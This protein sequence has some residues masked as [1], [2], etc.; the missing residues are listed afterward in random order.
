MN[1]APVFLLW[2][3]SLLALVASCH[4]FN[5]SGKMFN[6]PVEDKANKII[7]CNPFA[8]V[9]IHDCLEQIPH[10]ANAFQKEI[11]DRTGKATSLSECQLQ[12][13]LPGFWMEEN[14]CQKI[15]CNPGESSLVDC[16]NT[17]PFA[18]AAHFQRTCN[19]QG[20]NYLDE[21]CQLQQCRPEYQHQGNHCQ[22]ASCPAGEF[23]VEGQCLEV[24]PGY[25]SPA[26][27][28][29]RY[30]CPT[31]TYSAITNAASCLNCNNRP[32]HA[33]EVTYAATNQPTI[34]NNCPISS[35]SCTDEFAPDLATYSCKVLN[36]GAG[37]YA[38]AGKCQNVGAGFYSGPSDNAR[39]PCP[40]GF[41]SSGENATRC[42]ACTLQIAYA[43]SFTFDFSSALTSNS[44]PLAS[45]SCLNGFHPN[46]VAKSCDPLLCGA[47]QYLANNQCIDVTAGYYSPDKDNNRY[48]CP[49][50]KYSPISKASACTNCTNQPE[51]AHTVTYG[52][53]S[54]LTSNTCP[55]SSFTCQEGYQA[56]LANK[57]CTP[58][59][60]GTGQY[61]TNGQCSNVGQG[62]YSPALDNQRYLCPS[63][64]YSAVTNAGQ[65][66]PCTNQPAN[67]A[68]VTYGESSGLMSNM[69]PISSLT[70][71]NGY[72]VNNSSKK[73]E[74][75]PGCEGGKYLVNGVCINVGPGYFS[76]ANNNFRQPCGTNYYSSSENAT[77]CTLCSNLPPNSLTA[78]YAPSSAL[79]SNTC[80]IAGL[81]C[82][83]G[84]QFNNTNKSCD[85]LQNCD[86]GMCLKNGLCTN[87]GPGAFSPANNNICYQCLGGTYSDLPNAGFCLPC[88]NKPEN[89]ATVTYT[90][91]LGTTSNNCPIATFS[92]LLGYLPNNNA[93]TCTPDPAGIP[94]KIINGYNVVEL[95]K[96]TYDIAF[97]LL[98]SWQITTGANTL[99]ALVDLGSHLGHSSLAGNIRPQL[100]YDVVNK[101]ANANEQ[102]FNYRKGI[103]THVNGIISALPSS[104]TTYQGICPQCNLAIIKSV[105][106]NESIAESGFPY[107]VGLGAGIVQLSWGVY[108]FSSS[109]NS[110]K[111]FCGMPDP[112]TWITDYCQTLKAASLR[113]TLIIVPSGNYD[114]ALA[115][116]YRGVQFPANSS[117]AVAVGGVYKNFTFAKG[118]PKSLSNS[119]LGPEQEFVAPFLHVYSTMWPGADWLGPEYYQNYHPC[120]DSPVP[121]SGWGICSGT[122]M[123]AAFISGIAGLIKSLRPTI[124]NTSLRELLR[125]SASQN[126]NDVTDTSPCRHQE[127][128][129]GRPQV[130]KIITAL[131]GAKLLLDTPMFAL[132]SAEAPNLKLF[133]TSPQLAMSKI[134]LEGYTP[135][136]HF[137]PGE[138]PTF[139]LYKS[140]KADRYLTVLPA[141]SAQAAFYIFTHQ[142]PNLRPL[143]RLSK[144]FGTV[145]R[146]F[147]AVDTEE[148][149]AKMQEGYIFE[150]AE[151]YVQTKNDSTNSLRVLYRAHHLTKND[152][153]LFAAG[154]EAEAI[155]EGYTMNRVVLG[156]IPSK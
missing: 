139:D 145:T 106:T 16:T 89:A 3:Y 141:V 90:Q 117:L 128:G 125:R 78:T 34:S 57:I 108:E 71:E 11:C 155:A 142:G 150:S 17:I 50:G 131:F 60:C 136:G 73:C 104:S 15:I 25:Y 86:V 39:Y 45:L 103:G 148:L 132:Q 121:P 19:E 124:S 85:A 118:D 114:G 49:S 2:V 29:N 152:Y 101:S 7:S 61:L 109:N 88:T 143:L 14:S 32:A 140:F 72:Q 75:L 94:E 91:A 1:A 63:R 13:C 37:L 42:E 62:Y 146:Y 70:C 115:S 156:Y 59:L 107:A 23:A 77:A 129:F 151:G 41:F 55:W 138:Y 95:N 122:N 24:G 52:A 130:K 98:D 43:A 38:H 64:T 18:T 8:L 36:C 120:G 112:P 154:K 84:Y 56:N 58:I 93:K 27:D 153:L 149:N 123:S 126:C 133:T 65:C 105:N 100:S 10:A 22:L 147:Y 35:F 4:S 6:Q 83:P 99:V 96:T 87:V 5:P 54:A 97:G 9:K 69:C 48:P 137:S 53:S 28:A 46:V 30:L 81:T 47:G 31:G 111:Y 12:Q 26:N 51:N 102:A 74:A 119:R 134:D 44:C 76:P 20:T 79:T 67:A 135:S 127:Q 40:T 92:C 66:L 21:P 144:N 113:N 80:P 33:I 82:R 110:N 68:T 116:A